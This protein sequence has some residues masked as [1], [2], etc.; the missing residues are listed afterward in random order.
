[1]Y[2]LVVNAGSSSLKYQLFDM[3][4]REVIAK[5]LCERIG[6]D[7]KIT[8][9]AVGKPDYSADI[10]MPTHS[11][12]TK[13][14]IDSLLDKEHGCITDMSQIGAVGHRIVNGGEWLTKPVLVDE[15]VIA[16]LEK[17]RDIA[18][19]HTVPHLMGIRGCMTVMPDT[20]QV[21]VIDTAFHRTMPK[22]AYFYPI[23]YELYRKYKIRRYGFHGTSHRYVSEKAIE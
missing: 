6:I 13:A 15:Q 21:L 11:E 1:M 4:T 8:H 19:L 22:K 16:D 2:V 12:A 9:H 7:G 23:P 14:L 3:D 18:P 5:G 17:C 10:P 20:P